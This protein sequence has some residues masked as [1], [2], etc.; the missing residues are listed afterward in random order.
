MQQDIK[1]PGSH[2]SSRIQLG[3]GTSFLPGTK[4]E[5]VKELIDHVLEHGYVILPRLF[6]ERLVEE[7]KEE[8]GRLEKAEWEGRRREGG[9]NGFEGFKTRRV[10][11][12]ADK[13]R[14]FDEFAINETV[15]K[16]NDYFLQ[17]N[18]LL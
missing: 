9:R 14:V 15:L 10:Y 13:S 17:Q 1:S 11:A 16:L 18:Y 12:L 3:Q 8:V 6:S 4:H 2:R 5:S 7:A